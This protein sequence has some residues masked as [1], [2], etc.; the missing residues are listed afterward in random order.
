MSLLAIL[1]ASLTLHP[2]LTERVSATSNGRAA[3]MR[4]SDSFN[5]GAGALGPTNGEVLRRVLFQLCWPM[6]LLLV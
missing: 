1:V 3:C 2:W 5:F 6:H 4:C